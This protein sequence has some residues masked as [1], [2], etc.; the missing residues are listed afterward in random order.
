L[1]PREEIHCKTLLFTKRE[2]RHT[3]FPIKVKL[4]V[5]RMRRLAAAGGVIVHRI[6][7]F[8]GTTKPATVRTFSYKYIK[9]RLKLK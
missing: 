9:R 7:L 2:K 4:V 3:H 8:S 5:Y 6:T 1:K